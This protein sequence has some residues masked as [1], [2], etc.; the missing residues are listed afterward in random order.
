MNRP[1]LEAMSRAQAFWYPIDAF[2]L[3]ARVLGSTKLVVEASDMSLTPHLVMD[4]FWES[5]ISVWAMQ[6]VVKTDRVLNIGANCGYYTMLFAH[7]CARVVA[8]EPQVR[9]AANIRMSARLNGL[10]NVVE[11]IE[12]VAGS[13]ERLVTLQMHHSLTGSAFVQEEK[14]SGEWGSPMEVQERPAH[15]LMPDATCAF[16]DAEGYEPHIWE[17]LQ[18][19]LGKKQLRWVAMEWSPTRYD[20][21]SDFLDALQRYGNL[22][23][24]HGNGAEVVATRE[25]LLAGSEWDTLVVKP[26]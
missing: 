11:V 22:S 23:L 16:I 25:A 6:N 24:V 2:R 26:R 7:R 4:G 8:V 17:G 19:L 10:S 5:W 14:M 1:Q 13:K 21:A 18:P 9:L 12:G 15:E 3:A 20:S